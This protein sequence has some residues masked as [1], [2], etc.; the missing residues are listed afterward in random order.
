MKSILFFFSFF[1]FQ[2]QAQEKYTTT[3]FNFPKDVKEIE[4]D[5]F[6]INRVTGDKKWFKKTK[7][8]FLDNLLQSKVETYDNVSSR[9]FSYSYE[10]NKLTKFEIKDNDFIYT[11]LYTY[12]KKNQ[13]KEIK[14]LDQNVLTNII[15]FNYNSNGLLKSKLI[16][17]ADGFISCQEDYMYISK[18]KYT[19]RV[20]F[21]Y[22]TQDPI[23]DEYYY[24]NQLQ[25]GSKS[26]IS[27]KEPFELFKKYDE[28]G[29]LIEVR[30]PV[31]LYFN[32]Y[33]ANGYLIQTN[34]N[35]NDNLL[36]IILEY[37]YKF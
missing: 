24:E 4:L 33:D 28:K 37:H 17:E 36:Y 3:D 25:I 26:N 9:F 6:E 34:I 19:K 12:N 15:L 20:T 5:E 32:K 7:Y 8:V 1:F 14:A 2:L 23:I 27:G 35:T 10:G 21:K 31:T 16:K 29:N 18:N 30:E 22:T 11:E 13:L